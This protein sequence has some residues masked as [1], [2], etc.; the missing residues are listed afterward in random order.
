MSFGDDSQLR[1]CLKR[2]LYKCVRGRL[3]FIHFYITIVLFEID[4]SFALLVG[5]SYL[6][7]I[8]ILSMRFKLIYLTVTHYLNMVIT[9]RKDNVRGA[10]VRSKKSF[11]LFTLLNVKTGIAQNAIIIFGILYGRPFRD[12]KNSLT[13]TMLDV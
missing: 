8:L 10:F 12:L 9:Q 5:C 6:I 3:R 13:A 11:N 2:V 4:A 1:E 7:H